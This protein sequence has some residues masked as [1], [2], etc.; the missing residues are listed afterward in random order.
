M[1]FTSWDYSSSF[2]VVLIVPSL[3]SAVG[4]FD[5]S[6]E[7]SLT[8]VLHRWPAPFSSMPIFFPGRQS[9]AY[10][11]CVKPSAVGNY[12]I[13]LAGCRRGEV[14]S[15]RAAAGSLNRKEFFMSNADQRIVVWVQKFKDRESLVLQ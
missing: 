6:D 7:V 5:D 9:L 10:H 15:T 2:H 1:A 11:A 12:L 8:F 13:P 4:G 3:L 14:E